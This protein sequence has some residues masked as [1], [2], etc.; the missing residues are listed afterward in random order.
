MQST[1]DPKHHSLTDL[2][3][4]TQRKAIAI[5]FDLQL[6]TDHLFA[7]LTLVTQAASH[8]PSNVPAYVSHAKPTARRLL[9]REQLEARKPIDISG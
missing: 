4:T 6:A 5:P 9:P 1:T 3:W 7:T 2:E 8:S